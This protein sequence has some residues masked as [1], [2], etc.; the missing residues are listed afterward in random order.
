MATKSPSSPSASPASMILQLQEQEQLNN[1]YTSIQ[2]E[3]NEFKDV[4]SQFQTEE[5]F[6]DYGY[7]NPAPYF[8][9]GGPAPIP[10]GRRHNPKEQKS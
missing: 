6:Q 3:L 10:H 9:R 2:E 4:E 7:W 8:G 1:V 5:E